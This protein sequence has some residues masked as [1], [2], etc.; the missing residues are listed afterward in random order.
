MYERFLAATNY[1]PCDVCFVMASFASSSLI[2]ELE[3]ELI[4][5]RDML[6]V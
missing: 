4:K 1:V 2:F 3:R 5:S 6:S